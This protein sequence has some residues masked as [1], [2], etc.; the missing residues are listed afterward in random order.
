MSAGQALA[1]LSGSALIGGALLG[2]ATG[3]DSMGTGA[4]PDTSAWSLG[5]GYAFKWT[6]VLM[7]VLGMILIMLALFAM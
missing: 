2:V 4:F 1:L 7:I 5:S 3:W 6:D